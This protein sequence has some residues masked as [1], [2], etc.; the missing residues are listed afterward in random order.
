MDLS[1]FDRDSF[2]RGASRGKEAA[3]LAMRAVLFAGTFLPCYGLRRNAL[4]WFGAL[5]GEGVVIK[6]GARI[7]F[8]WRLS[9]GDHAWVGEDSWILNLAPVHIGAH[10]CIS[11]RAFLCT[12][13]HNWS[14]PR[15]ALRNG[16][17]DIGAGAWICAG[18]LVGPGV[19]VGAGAVATA[20]SVVVDDLP[21][22]MICSGN[23]CRP[24]RAREENENAD[25]PG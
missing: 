17:I 18:V 13:N 15:F 6:P 9:L 10:A 22:N 24:V 3:W 23:P 7:T 25:L 5:V 4:R 14:D 8:P 12:G 19:T 16:A 21:P 11:Q 20:G 2:D 1:S